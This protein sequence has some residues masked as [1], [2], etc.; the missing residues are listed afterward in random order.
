M[1]RHGD[2][3]YRAQCAFFDWARYQS[4]KYPKLDLLYASANGGQ[5]NVVVA[6]KLKASGVRAGIPDVHFP[7]S[8]GGYHSLYLEVKIKPNRLTEN[9]KIWIALLSAAGNLVLVAWSSEEMI[10]QTMDYINGKYIREQT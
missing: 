3:E 10:R 5:R 1:K 6:A 4:G 2:K 9:Q 8:R 7:V